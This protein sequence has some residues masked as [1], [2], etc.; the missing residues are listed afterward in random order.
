M[1]CCAVILE[2]KVSRLKEEKPARVKATHEVICEVQ[3]TS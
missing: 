1:S 2:A 3:V